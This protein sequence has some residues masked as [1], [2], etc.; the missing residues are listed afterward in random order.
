MDRLVRAEDALNS[1][2]FW[3]DMESRLE[4]LCS[5]FYKLCQ[6]E[7]P[8]QALIRVY[9]R[10]AS[11]DKV[12]EFLSAHQPNTVHSISNNPPAIT[13]VLRRDQEISCDY[14]CVEYKQIYL[15]PK[16]KA[17]IKRYTYFEIYYD[18]YIVSCLMDLPTFH[19][20]GPFESLDMDPAEWAHAKL[21]LKLWNKLL[22]PELED[23]DEITDIISSDLANPFDERLSQ[24]GESDVPAE[25][26]QYPQHDKIIWPLLTY[27]HLMQILPILPKK[28][29]P[30]CMI[31]YVY[32]GKYKDFAE[33]LASYLAQCLD[34]D[35]ITTMPLSQSSNYFRRSDERDKPGAAEPY[36]FLLERISSSQLHEAITDL[37]DYKR[38]RFRKW[39]THPFLNAVPICVG[40]NP[41]PNSL[42]INIH[43]PKDFVLPDPNIMKSGF[44]YFWKALYKFHNKHRR[45]KNKLKEYYQKKK[46]AIDAFLDEQAPSFNRSPLYPLSIWFLVMYEVKKFSKK[47]HIKSEE[48]KWLQTWIDSWSQEQRTLEE[49]VQCLLDLIKEQRIQF[50]KEAPNNIEEWDL[51]G[52]RFFL[53]E[54]DGRNHIVCGLKYLEQLILSSSFKAEKTAIVSYLIE[55]KYLSTSKGRNNYNIKVGDKTVS[56]YA[57]PCDKL[58]LQ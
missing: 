42:V 19:K 50:L 47:S 21:Q 15:I 31:N 11:T 7:K 44:L 22:R 39:D 38:S 17:F 1:V 14:I 18:R 30:C 37:E 53:K 55:N 33:Q 41:I 32:P 16:S 12:L 28:Q 29:I 8:R 36:L 34:T 24:Y 10:T 43:V 54:I 58:D 35:P 46:D 40:E 20:N 52:G 4:K 48:N 6:G 26:L 13:F 2:S 45:Q 23:F 3:C 9:K 49:E 5:R 27:L 57:F 25:S 51:H 56:T